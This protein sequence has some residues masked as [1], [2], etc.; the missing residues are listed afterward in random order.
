MRDDL[1]VADAAVLV[2]DEPREM[3]GQVPDVRVVGV[4]PGVIVPAAAVVLRLELGGRGRAR[5]VADPVGA[6]VVAVVVADLLE[7]PVVP[8]V[9]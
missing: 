7:R 9:P 1:D 4:S 8:V 5:V 3:P 6:V 2:L